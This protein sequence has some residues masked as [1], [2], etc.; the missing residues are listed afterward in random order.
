[1]TVPP[2][3][4]PLDSGRRDSIGRVVRVSGNDTA[5]RA[6]APPPPVGRHD[7][8]D[9]KARFA[10]AAADKN[11]RSHLDDINNLFTINLT[12]PIEIVWSTGN[13]SKGGHFTPATR[14]P[15]PKKPSRRIIS[16]QGREAYA[17]A[18][19]EY[20]ERVRVYNDTPTRPQIRVVRRKDGSDAEI[21][22]SVF[23][24]WAHA[25]DFDPADN[26]TLRP[27]VN[28]AETGAGKMLTTQR[29]QQR[30]RRQYEMPRGTVA[31]RDTLER[32]ETNPTDTDDPVFNF[33]AA[34]ARC[35]S[36]DQFRST[37][38][39]SGRRPDLQFVQYVK[40]PVEMWAR[41]VAQWA[42]R[43]LDGDPMLGCR[44][45]THSFTADEIEHLAPY[46]E[47]VLADRGLLRGARS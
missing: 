46:I 15:R 19:A 1:M 34:A 32:W 17:A 42:T 38:L 25:A 27:T 45:D 23:H 2:P 4:R 24:E 39:P 14:G 29:D 30:I 22:N 16:Q 11:L 3:H 20:R 40:S 28:G 31:T 6:D 5:S 47:S 12:E 10:T 41:A 37:P 44:D 21:R 43:A 7:D 33:I 8:L 26:P 9:T 18:Y 36:I 35:E 13:Q